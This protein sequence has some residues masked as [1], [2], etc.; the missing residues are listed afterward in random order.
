MAAW[1]VH[2]GQTP[3]VYLSLNRRQRDEFTKAQ[4][5]QNKG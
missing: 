4:N 5:R 2:T 3:D 1:C